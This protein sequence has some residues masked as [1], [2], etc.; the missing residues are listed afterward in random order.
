MKF[1]NNIPYQHLKF[2][3]NKYNTLTVIQRRKKI[4][5]VKIRCMSICKYV[6]HSYSREDIMRYWYLMYNR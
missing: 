3:N 2:E 4:K 1:I 6:G 5:L